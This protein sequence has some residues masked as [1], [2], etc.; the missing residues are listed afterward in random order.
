MDDPGRYYGGYSMSCEK[1]AEER[2]GKFFMKEARIPRSVN[3]D[4]WRFL[5]MFTKVAGLS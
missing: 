4:E 1:K 2:H 3:G 5:F